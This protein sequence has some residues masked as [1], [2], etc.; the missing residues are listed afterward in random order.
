[1]AKRSPSQRIRGPKIVTVPPGPKSK[2]AAARKSKFVTNGVRIGL[3]IDVTWA[4]GSLVRDA[5]GN[6][7]VDLGGGI[8]VQTVGHR[9]PSVIRAAKDQLDRLTPISCM[10]ASYGP[11]LDLAK[12]MA[13]I[14][15]PGLTK[16]IFLNSGSEAIENAV[17]IA[18]FATKRAWL[19]SFKT[20]FHGRTLLDISLTGKEKPY[21]EGLVRW[22][23]RSSSPTTPI[24]IEI[25]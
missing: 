1:M 10:V 24:R 7:Y 22:S 9:P 20:A 25:P 3:P 14:A 17:K 21:R 6:V 12:R 2:A 5:D 16:S 15:P 13:D 23:G 11:Y 18:R 4:E 19:A 8:G